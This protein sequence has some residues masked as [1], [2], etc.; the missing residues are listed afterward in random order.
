MTVLRFKKYAYKTI[1]VKNP[2]LN[3]PK[4][5]QRRPLR[6]KRNTIADRALLNIANMKFSP[7]KSVEVELSFSRYKSVLRPIRRVFNFDHL[8]MF[9]VFHCNHD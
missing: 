6:N 8:S 5:N 1:A 4:I 2:G 9:M 3:Y 7:I